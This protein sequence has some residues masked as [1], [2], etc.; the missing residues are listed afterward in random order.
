MRRWVI[1]FPDG[2]YAKGNTNARYNNNVSLELAKM[3]KSAG[4]AKNHL[5]GIGRKLA[6]KMYPEGTQIVEVEVTVTSDELSATRVHDYFEDKAKRDE[7]YRL[8]CRRARAESDLEDAKRR[9]KEAE[10]TV[11]RM[12]NEH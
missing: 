10:A 4:H 3:W 9:L 11:N 12:N 8:S 2:T 7:E 6:K 1:K 5:N